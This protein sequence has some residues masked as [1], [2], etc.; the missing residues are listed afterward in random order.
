MT[1]A[2][3]IG[4]AFTYKV[5]INKTNADGA[6]LPGAEFKLEKLLADG[7]KEEISTEDRITEKTTTFSFKGLDD[8]DYVLTEKKVPAGC[9]RIDPIE[10][11]VTADHKVE[12]DVTDALTRTSV[13]TGLT[14]KTDWDLVIAFTY[15]LDINK[16]D[17]DGNALSGAA[18]KLEKVLADGSLKEVS[19]DAS[20]SSDTKFSYKGLDDGD[21]VL[22]ETEAPEGCIAID[23]VRFTVAADHSVTW[24]VKDDSTRTSV[25]TAL[26]GKSATGEIT[27]ASDSTLTG[28]SGD[29]EN[30]LTGVKVSKVDVSN[31]MKPLKGATLQLIDAQGNVV[32]TWVTN[33][34]TFLFKGLKTGTT[35]TIHESKYPSGYEREPNGDVKFKID[36]DGNVKVINHAG[37]MKGDT[38]QV[39]NAP[40]G[41]LW[42]NK[43]PKRYP[44]MTG[45]KKQTETE[46]KKKKETETEKIYKGVKTGDD[47][48]I[49]QW[50]IVLAAALA[51]IGAATVLM[52]KRRRRRY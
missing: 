2:N 50:V 13:L 27:F 43:Y 51:G 45:K 49:L 23:P 8:G 39:L 31:N 9:K 1:R 35:Y 37:D 19:L 26:T 25:L 14:G 28:L 34:K 24:D 52:M 3:G 33:G 36:E 6:A 41:F 44:E 40:L 32:K 17:P 7:S 46:T 20:A 16:T 29:V 12:W 11:T 42:G 38:I 30:D 48:P 5:N 21:Y 18:F 22:T 4:I 47:T 15:K 10:F